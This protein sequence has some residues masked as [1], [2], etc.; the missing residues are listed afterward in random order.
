MEQ[1]KLKPGLPADEGILTTFPSIDSTRDVGAEQTKEDQLLNT[2]ESKVKDLALSMVSAASLELNFG[3]AKMTINLEKTIAEL[4]VGVSKLA[5]GLWGGTRTRDAPDITVLAY[6]LPVLKPL[7]NF[8]QPIKYESYEKLSEGQLLITNPSV[9]FEFWTTTMPIFNAI[10]FCGR[11]LAA[12]DINA[13]HRVRQGFVHGILPPGPMNI[14]RRQAIHHISNIVDEIWIRGGSIKD[15]PN[16][17]KWSKKFPPLKQCKTTAIRDLVRLAK[18]GTEAALEV[19]DI[20]T[21]AMAFGL[22]QVN[23]CKIMALGFGSGPRIYTQDEEGFRELKLEPSVRESDYNLF[24]YDERSYFFRLCG[25]PAESLEELV[26]WLDNEVANTTLL[27]IENGDA[28]GTVVMTPSFCVLARTGAIKSLGDM[29]SNIGMV[30]A[31]N[32]KA[33]GGSCVS[34]LHRASHH[35]YVGCRTVVFLNM[36][37]SVYVG[38]VLKKAG[39]AIDQCLFN[40]DLQ[41]TIKGLKELIS[42]DNFGL[43]AFLTSWYILR[44]GDD[45]P[46]VDEGT[47][48]G[49]EMDGQIHGLRHAVK[50]GTTGSPLV[51][52]D[53]HI[54]AGSHTFACLVFGPRPEIH[55]ELKKGQFTV[56]TEQ[57]PDVLPAQYLYVRSEPKYIAVDTILLYPT[58]DELQVDLGAYV[59]MS[60]V[61]RCE[62]TAE[63]MAIPLYVSQCVDGC[64]VVN[65]AEEFPY[66]LYTY[67]N[68]SLQSWI[69]GAFEGRAWLQGCRPLNAALALINPGEVLIQGGCKTLTI[70]QQRIE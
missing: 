34:M 29:V 42:Y 41:R 58:G 65:L 20:Y 31:E 3:V 19:S 9:S 62:E 15:D 23:L 44:S 67:G 7:V 50:P 18:E 57:P 12:G 68:E 61:H 51:S 16:W 30:V 17:R 43:S 26:K 11:V 53:G 49:L 13:G 21:A 35:E 69:Y 14:N 28:P 48:L 60:Y 24:Y 46:H 47:V 56:V 70:E 25:V 37:I 59:N 22:A 54:A 5:T 64:S 32:C 39:M 27:G 66:A 1:L 2:G 38:G 10:L 55:H 52:F 36:L 4:G 8:G 6:Y 40:G 33:C 45:V 63:E